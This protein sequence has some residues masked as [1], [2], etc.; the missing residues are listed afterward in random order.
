MRNFLWIVFFGLILSLSFASCNDTKTYAREVAA[1]KALIDDFIKRNGIVLVE[2]LPTAD[3]FF[4]NKNLY[5]K[6]TSGLYYRLEKQGLLDKDTLLSA[7]RLQIDV[8][9][10]AYTLEQKADT[11]DYSSPQNHIGTSFIYGNLS[12][13]AAS[14]MEAASYM[15]RS[16]SEAKIIVPHRIGFNT[17]DVKP[18]GYDLK[19][20]FRKDVIPQ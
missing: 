18:Y 10:L 9:Y 11:F 16:E 20:Q 3:E 13:T 14:F 5:Y 17:S 2:K 7:D 19:I 1:E 6:S 12:S 8:K 4:N 15:K